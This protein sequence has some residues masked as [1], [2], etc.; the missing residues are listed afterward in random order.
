MAYLGSCGQ[1]GGVVEPGLIETSLATFSKVEPGVVRIIYKDDSR[2]TMAEARENLQA[3]VQVAGGVRS[4]V[5]ID[6]RAVSTID[7]ESRQYFAGDEAALVNSATA[8][9]VGSPI[10]RVIGNFFIG[11]NRP[12]WPVHVFSEE[13]A[14]MTW[15]EG[16]LD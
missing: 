9:L 6:I 2:V 12:A 3:T 16:F 14:A 8:M 11:L 15:L 13:A 1:Q 7:R 10:S 5:F 4:P